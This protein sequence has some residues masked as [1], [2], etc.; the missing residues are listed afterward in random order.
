[1][2]S[3][4]AGSLLCGEKLVAHKKYFNYEVLNMKQLED[5]IFW[6]GKFSHF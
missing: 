4:K 1:M 5:T 2:I 6:W 3:L